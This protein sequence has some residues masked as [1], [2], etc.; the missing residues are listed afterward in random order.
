MHK[1]S[2]ERKIVL[3]RHGQTAWTVSGQHTGLTDIPLNTQ[4]E[5]QATGL[6]ESLKSHV[7]EK[8]LT[9][10]LIRAKKTCELAGFLKQAEIDQDL[11]E[12]NYGYY[13]G[14]TKNEI[15]TSDPEWNIFTKGAKGGE[16]IEHVSKRADLVLKKIHS[17]QGDVLLFSSGH[18]LRA[19]AARWLSYPLSFGRQIALSPASISILGYENG[20]PVLQLWNRTMEID[21]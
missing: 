6:A 10:P 3:V 1:I 5:K 14:K 4:G 12:W 8:V 18:F 16:S 13:E 2:F 20:Y 9:S 15:L 7:F 17:F 21:F 19:L 11:V